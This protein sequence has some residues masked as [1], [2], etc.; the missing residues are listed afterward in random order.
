MVKQS[1]LEITEKKEL[2]PP[3]KEF[4]WGER[5]KHEFNGLDIL[6]YVSKV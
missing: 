6:K 1:Y 2:D 5:T 3:I 4:R